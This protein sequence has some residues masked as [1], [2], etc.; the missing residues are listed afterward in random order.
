MFTF[1]VICSLWPATTAPLSGVTPSQDEPTLACQLSGL[2][3]VL[4][5]FTAWSEGLACPWVA[6]KL[7]DD[8][9][10]LSTADGDVGVAEAVVPGVGEPAEAVAVGF[11]AP[12]DADGEGED[13]SDGEG[14]RESDGEGESDGVGARF[15]AP[16]VVS[17][18]ALS[19]GEK[20]DIFALCC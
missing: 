7:R 16:G 18:V 17:V 1:T 5:M 4:A 2:P 6:L 3:P 15:I 9:D 11:P 10:T 19:M 12:G 14:E 8:A 13:E 20:P